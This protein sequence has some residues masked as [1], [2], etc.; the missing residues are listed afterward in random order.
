MCF[1]S[2]CLLY[3][4]ISRLLKDLKVRSKK[5]HV[6]DNS[7]V[8]K[9]EKISKTLDFIRKKTQTH[10]GCTHDNCGPHGGG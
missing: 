5:S 9:A 2:L 8:M 1:V 10:K 6:S 7:L 3:L 4:K